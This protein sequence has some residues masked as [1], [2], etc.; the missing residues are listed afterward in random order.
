MLLLTKSTLHFIN[1][2]TIFSDND[3]STIEGQVKNWNEVVLSATASKWQSPYASLPSNYTYPCCGTPISETPRR[4]WGFSDLDPPTPNENQHHEVH[5]SPIAVDDAAVI[6]GNEYS[7]VGNV[8]MAQEADMSNTQH[9]DASKSAVGILKRKRGS[10]M[11]DDSKHFSKGDSVNKEENAM[12][13]R[14][15]RGHQVT[16]KMF[17]TTIDA[18][19]PH[20]ESRPTPHIIC[21]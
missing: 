9:V 20:K 19:E 18:D 21:H 13:E 8:D 12:V 11:E 4:Q 7:D 14:I 2:K 3:K 15:A 16:S 5:T 17:V 10:S 6:V 1:L